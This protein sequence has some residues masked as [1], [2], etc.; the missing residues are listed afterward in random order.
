MSTLGGFAQLRCVNLVVALDQHQSTRPSKA[1]HARFAC[2]AGLGGA[3]RHR[4][5]DNKLLVAVGRG[6]I[7]L[8]RGRQRSTVQPQLHQSCW[9][10]EE[11]AR[12][13]AEDWRRCKRGWRL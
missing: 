10:G 9:H 6:G 1:R 5:A 3:E 7:A 2:D 12:A 8:H 11:E 13:I 4:I